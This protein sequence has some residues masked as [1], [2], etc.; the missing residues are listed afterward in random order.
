MSGLTLY[1]ELEQ[2]CERLEDAI[3]ERDTARG[4]AVRLEQEIARISDQVVTV[5]L[6]YTMVNDAGYVRWNC[7]PAQLLDAYR[8]GLALEEI[9]AI[10]DSPIPNEDDVRYQSGIRIGLGMALRLIDLRIG[11]GS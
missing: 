11:V 6:D 3:A 4:I 8:L 9:R 1:M 2:A 5:V 7:T 10:A